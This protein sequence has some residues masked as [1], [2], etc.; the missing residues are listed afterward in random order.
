MN[1]LLFL[2]LLITN[3]VYAQSGVY[4]DKKG[5]A[6]NQAEG[7]YVRTNVSGTTYKSTYINGETIYFEGQITQASSTDEAQ[8]K[9]V[10]K[11]KWYFKNGKL[12]F[13]KNF[14]DQ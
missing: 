5:K 1:R 8:N 11:C 14:T 7:Y 2:L 6:S 13:E 12:K 4:F 9:Y 10:G 3:T